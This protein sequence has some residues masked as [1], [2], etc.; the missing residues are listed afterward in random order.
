MISVVIPLYNKAPFVQKAIDSVLA[1]TITDWELVVV[2]DGSSDDG[3][4]LV[5]AYADHRIKL[6]KQD[7]AGVGAARNKGAELAKYEMLAFLDADDYWS[8]THLENLQQLFVEFPTASLYGTAYF[9]IGSD[10]VARICKFRNANI[11]PERVLI[12]DYFTDLVEYGL[13]IV[14]SSVAINKTWFQEVKGFP[15]TIKSG[16]DLLTWARLA[17]IGE[18][19]FSKIATS[20][21]NFPP[22]PA[23][24]RRDFI[25]RPLIPDYVSGELLK[26]RDT[27]PKFNVS[28]SRYLAFW[29]RIRAMLF[30]ELNER[31][32]SLSELLKAVRIDRLRLKDLV[33]CFLLILPLAIRSHTLAKIRKIR[34]RV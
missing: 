30:L 27:T 29:H 18:V 3:P 9:G 12:A 21:Y 2:D 5:S 23:I 16:E 26:L 17:C 10:G 19:A 25:R 11:E 28:I 31:L 14:T 20:Y 1:Q 7:N 13:F 24:N 4:A 34:G 33:C 8:S 15:V 22:V 6:I 32:N